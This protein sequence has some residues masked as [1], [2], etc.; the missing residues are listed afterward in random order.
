MLAAAM[1]SSDDPNPA[2]A[3]GGLPDIPVPSDAAQPGLNP[4]NATSPVL[5]VGA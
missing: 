2:G 5:P 1:S 4:N 3:G